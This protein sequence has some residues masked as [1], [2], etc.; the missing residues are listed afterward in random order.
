[1]SS[2][3]RFRTLAASCQAEPPKTKGSRFIGEAFPA[4][5]EAVAMKAVETVRKREHTAT[6]H[7]WAFRLGPSGDVVRFNDD[8]EPSGTAGPPI[9]RQ[10]EAHNIT[11]AVVIVTRYYGGTKLGTGGLA[12]AYGDAAD[13]VLEAARIVVKTVRERLVVRFA[14]ADT[15]PAMQL[16][17]RFDAEMADTEYIPEGTALTLDVRAS[18][19]DAFVRAFTN[20]LGGRGEVERTASHSTS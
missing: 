15:S 18:Q 5:S 13:A 1:M 2:A 6:H 19:V 7:C 3:D 17:E 4:S 12:R 14:F 10:L 9:L 20:A 11:D 16:V 8:G